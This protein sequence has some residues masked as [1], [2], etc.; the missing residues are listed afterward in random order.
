MEWLEGEGALKG[1]DKVILHE[2]A[3]PGNSPS[4]GFKTPRKHTR[5]C[6][7]NCS[8]KKTPLRITYIVKTR[9]RD[10]KLPQP[11]R[12]VPDSHRLLQNHEMISLASKEAGKQA[13]EASQNPQ[14]PQS[15]PSG[16]VWAW[17]SLHFLASTRVLLHTTLGGSVPQLLA[18]SLH[19]L[20]R[21][22]TKAAYEEAKGGPA[23]RYHCFGMV[24]CFWDHFARWC[25]FWAGRQA[26]LGGEDGV[27]EENP[28]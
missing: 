18:A 14:A 28:T 9:R 13:S 20:A 10:S 24:F 19:P 2:H 7:S 17:P 22:S 8:K 3:V 23:C 16:V 15:L 11:F 4:P 26:R 1:R 12:V 21:I 6:L 27:K 25:G 5:L